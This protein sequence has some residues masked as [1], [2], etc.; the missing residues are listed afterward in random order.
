VRITH[1]ANKD[2]LDTSESTS[3]FQNISNRRV[4]TMAANIKVIINP[5]MSFTEKYG[6]KGILS[7]FLFNPSGLFDPVSCKNRRWI[8]KTNPI[9]NKGI[10][11]NKKVVIIDLPFY[12]IIFQSIK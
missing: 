3:I 11:S 8:I 6:W 5:T 12:V 1:L 4:D 10:Q 2:F 9:N 7:E